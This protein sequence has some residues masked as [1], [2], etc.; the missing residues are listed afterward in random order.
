MEKVEFLRKNWTALPT[1]WLEWNSPGECLEYQFFG[2]ATTEKENRLELIADQGTAFGRLPC[3]KVIYKRSLRDLEVLDEMKKTIQK[4]SHDIDAE[5]MNWEVLPP[6]T[7]LH[8]I[9]GLRMG[10]DPETSIVDPSGRFWRIQNLYVA[11]ASSWPSQ[12]SAN[13][14][15]TITAW[16]LK[17]ADEMRL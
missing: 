3:C 12:G 2:I 17:L 11:D 5:L 14:Y 15:L 4:L 10:E 7:A 1:K 9:G 13:P 6:G 8:D 16:A